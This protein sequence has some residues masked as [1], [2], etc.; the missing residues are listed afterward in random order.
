[1]HGQQGYSVAI[2]G[3]KIVTGN[4]LPSPMLILL[5]GKISI[6]SNSRWTETLYLH[7]V[8]AKL[9]KELAHD[10]KSKVYCI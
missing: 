10:K 9:K 4:V 1:M 3:A 8:F 7:A 5:G 6:R 2:H